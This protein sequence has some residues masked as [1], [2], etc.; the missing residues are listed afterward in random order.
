MMA[1]AVAESEDEDAEA[2][3]VAGLVEADGSSMGGRERDFSTWDMR[4]LACFLNWPWVMK[5]VEEARAPQMWDGAVEV[6]AKEMD[7]DCL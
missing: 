3:A 1:D 4:A 2:V 6:E 7:S 5:A